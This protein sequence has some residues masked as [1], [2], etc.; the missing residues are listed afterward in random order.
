MTLAGAVLGL[1]LGGLVKGSIGL[2]QNVVAAPLLANVLG[3]KRAVPVL[4]L[5]N[6]VTNAGQMW[7]ARGDSIH[8][9]RLT[10]LILFGFIGIFFGSTILSFAAN[11]QLSIGLSIAV[12]LYVALRAAKR[13][14]HMSRRTAA[15]TVAPAAL[16]IGVMQGATGVAGPLLGSYLSALGVGRE[17][18]I[19]TIAAV[20][21]ML[22]GF[23][24]AS[25]GALGRY[26]E[27]TI[28]LGIMCLAP[29]LIG[30]AAGTGLRKRISANRFEKVVL[31]GLL[32]LAGQS[33]YAALR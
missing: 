31:G 29:L 32:L 6:L 12:V 10:S 19:F 27:W 5:T 21:E 14:L 7:S 16:M 11:R 24:V 8:I 26:S 15:V 30:L 22:T 3:V 25:L 2:G 33:F 13:E 28:L 4:A 23:Q 1:L 20:F 9:R 17:E 18:F